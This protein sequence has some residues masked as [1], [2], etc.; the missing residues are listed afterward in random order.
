MTKAIKYVRMMWRKR[1]S[2][3]PDVEMILYIPVT[4]AVE[5][6]PTA[7]VAL[8][9]IGQVIKYARSGVYDAVLL[10]L[11]GSERSCNAE[12]RD[13]IEVAKQHGIGVVLGGEAYAPLIGIEQVL[14][15]ARLG[16]HGDPV[17]LHQKRREMT[18]VSRE[19]SCAEELLK[20]LSCF[21]DYFLKIN[22]R[23]WYYDS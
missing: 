15:G 19:V 18:T 21:R 20:D 10:R 22:Q 2:H 1:G 13:L 16:L 11:E 8:R 7:D 17:A 6:K 5:S 3:G 23:E 9:E 4:I 12:L 14:V